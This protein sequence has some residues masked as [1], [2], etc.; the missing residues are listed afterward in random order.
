VLATAP[1]LL[2]MISSRVACKQSTPSTSTVA[3]VLEK[4]PFHSQG[5]IKDDGLCGSTAMRLALMAV[6]AIAKPA[7]DGLCVA[8]R[9]RDSKNGKVHFR[10]FLVLNL[11][12]GPFQ[13]FQ[14]ILF[15]D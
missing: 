5:Q 10:F 13:V 12:P 14:P 8:L 2:A 7:W 6:H 11:V 3:Y 1:V 9:K 4:D 15:L